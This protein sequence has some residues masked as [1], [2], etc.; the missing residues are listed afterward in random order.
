MGD[1]FLKPA[2]RIHDEIKLPIAPKV[3]VVR[4][5]YRGNKISDKMAAGI[6][7]ML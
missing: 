5:P 7:K 3:T 2:K 1:P 4:N 6:N